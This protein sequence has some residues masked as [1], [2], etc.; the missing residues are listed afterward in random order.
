MSLTFSCDT[1]LLYPDLNP[2][3]DIAESLYQLNCTWYNID[4]LAITETY[5]KQT[6]GIKNKKQ[7]C[8][9]FLNKNRESTIG[10]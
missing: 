3:N 6:N 4:T 10:W 2:G 7:I 1:V 8:D 9:P 5:T